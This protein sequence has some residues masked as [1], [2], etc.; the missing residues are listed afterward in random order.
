MRIDEFRS[1]FPI[2]KDRAYLFSGAMAPAAD[3]VLSMARE[4]A[5]GL[6][7]AATSALRL[8][9]RRDDDATRRYRNCPPCQ[10]PPS[11]ADSQYVAGVQYR[12]AH[13]PQWLGRVKAARQRCRRPD[14]LPEQ[15]LPVA[16]TR[17]AGAPGSASVAPDAMTEAIAERTDDDTV[18]IVV[19]HVDPLT[20]IRHDLEAVAEVARR[21]GSAVMVDVAQSAGVLEIPTQL[22]EIQVVVGTTMKWLLGMPGI[23]FLYVDPRLTKS[24]ARVDIGY[25]GLALDG[26]PFPESWMPERHSDARRFELGLP[27]MEGL[28]PSVE[29]IRL[30]TELGQRLV[31]D[32]IS[33]LAGQCIEGLRE[34]GITVRT[35]MD[36]RYRA[37]VVAFD[38]P[39]APELAE[40]LRSRHVDVGGYPWGLGTWIHTHS[41]TRRISSA[42]LQA[43][44]TSSTVEGW[45]SSG[46]RANDSF[47][48]A[49]G[50][51]LDA[52]TE[53]LLDRRRVDTSLDL[54][55][56]QLSATGSVDRDRPRG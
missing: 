11:R 17:G 32:H 7:F 36:P 31:L 13:S 46:A 15:P 10:R 30:L 41:M 34:A 16:C 49:H 2:T 19:S 35:P 48:V 12:R 45:C 53:V 27:N 43:C 6:G 33:R 50:V 8:S 55:L 5:L 38:T 3:T 56:C 20:G 28:V 42:S 18:A 40:Y 44:T 52:P 1:R 24:V 14:Y 9:S 54:L 39:S 21:H 37:G 29:G 47:T 25:L 23:G 4:L 22:D 51:Y 26:E